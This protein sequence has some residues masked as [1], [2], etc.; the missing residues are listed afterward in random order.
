[1]A[2]VTLRQDGKE[3]PCGRVPPG[4]WGVHLVV[5]AYT[6][7]RNSDARTRSRNGFGASG[8]GAGGGALTCFGFIAVGA[9]PFAAFFAVALAARRARCLV[10]KPLA[11][12][13]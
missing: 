7:R 2:A 11:L 4:R 1:M 5:R 13:S 9:A 10:A 12:A 3:V 6:L 8:G